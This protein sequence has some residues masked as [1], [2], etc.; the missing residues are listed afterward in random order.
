[1]PPTAPTQNS[2]IPKEIQ[3]EI[4]DANKE[5]GK[6]KP[7]GTKEDFMAKFGGKPS[8]TGD[9][10]IDRG[11]E[12]PTE[13][14]KPPVGD[15][16]A[17]RQSRQD[18]RGD[19]GKSP[20]YVKTIQAEKAALQA[21]KE[22]LAKEKTELSSK[23]ADLQTQLESAKTQKDIDAIVAEKDKAIKEYTEST[24]SL[25][26]ENA[27]L[28]SRVTL[29]DL[30]ED[31]GFISTFVEPIT[32]TSK[33]VM[34]MLEG[35]DGAVD[36]MTQ[37]AA[38]NNAFLTADTPEKK[39]RFADQRDQLLSDIAEELPKFRQTAFIT[40][41]QNLISLSERRIDAPRNHEQTYATIKER[42]KA[43]REESARQ[44]SQQWSG[45]FEEVSK[46]IEAD[47]AIPKE[48]QDFMATNGIAVDNVLDETIA[49]SAIKD[50]AKDFGPRDVARI[51]KQGAAYKKVK[52][53]NS[54]LLKMN[55]ELNETIKELKGSGTSGQGGG[56]GKTPEAA[57]EEEKS[58]FFGRFAPPTR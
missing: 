27:K 44:V 29:V 12:K 22:A 57:K 8:T 32:Q 56:G 26:A 46:E 34:D 45:A 20:S 55:E 31:E 53:H 9:G 16:A 37:V 48:V 54:A 52:A 36:K 18:A 2:P 39:R 41:T 5:A 43:A 33:R 15:P 30:N 17:P 23:L 50:G 6:Q 7:L 24:E 49:S 38:L 14:E 51:L 11:A 47:S 35:N 40:E 28:K 42:Q 13:G 19:L 1:M 21:E 4:S 25:R 3:Q 10:T 58:K